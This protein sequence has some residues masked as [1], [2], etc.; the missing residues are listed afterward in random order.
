VFLD[1]GLDVAQADGAD[2]ADGLLGRASLGHEAAG[3]NRS[4]SAQAG[5]AVDDDRLLELQ[6]GE[7]LAAEPGRRLR[8]GD[9]H[10]GHREMDAPH[11][12]IGRQRREGL[13]GECD[14]QPDARPRDQRSGGSAAPPR[15]TRNNVLLPIPPGPRITPVQP[16]LR[17][18]DS[19][20]S[21]ARSP[22]KRPRLTSAAVTTVN[23]IRGLDLRR[24]K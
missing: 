18:N 2:L 23:T 4:R 17:S 14:E 21:T 6:G 15:S 24:Q 19:G 13:L 1:F 11:G 8:G 9:A 16:A 7:D 12:E 3:E 5:L 10:V 20:P 22:M